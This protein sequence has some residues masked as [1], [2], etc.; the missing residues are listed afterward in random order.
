MV[1][2][3]RV[4]RAFWDAAERDPKLDRLRK[5]EFMAKWVEGPVLSKPKP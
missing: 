2:N 5:S 4:A 1:A 3:V